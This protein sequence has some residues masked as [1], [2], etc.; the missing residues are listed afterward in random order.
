MRSDAGSAVTKDWTCLIMKKRLWQLFGLDKTLRRRDSSHDLHAHPIM[1][2]S[3]C[4]ESRW[5]AT[6]I[7]KR[8]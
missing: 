5:A 3:T 1:C 7:F 4:E 2:A 6:G 8:L